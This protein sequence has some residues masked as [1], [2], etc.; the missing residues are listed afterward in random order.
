MARLI[1]ILI[2]T[3]VVI[4]SCGCTDFQIKDPYHYR[5]IRIGPPFPLLIYKENK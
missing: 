2:F 3:T 4:L 1:K 5:G